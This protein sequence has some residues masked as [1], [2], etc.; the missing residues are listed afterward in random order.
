[1]KITV[2]DRCYRKAKQTKNEKGK[3]VFNN[4]I[5]AV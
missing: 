4:I 1:M 2:V 5:K 3:L